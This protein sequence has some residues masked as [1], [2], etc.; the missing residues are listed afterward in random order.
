MAKGVLRDCRVKVRVC[1]LRSLGF[2]V[3]SSKIHEGLG[4]KALDVGPYFTQNPCLHRNYVCI[5]ILVCLLLFISICIFSFPLVLILTLSFVYSY[6]Y[7]RRHVEYTHINKYIT[8]YR[9]T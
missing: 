4:L 9:Y 5:L 2:R 3:W 6:L 1:G 7:L 8:V